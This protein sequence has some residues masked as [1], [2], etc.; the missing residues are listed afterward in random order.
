MD[1]AVNDVFFSDIQEEGTV[2]DYVDGAFIFVIKDEMWT[3][4][5]TKGI[6]K[7]PLQIDFVYK[8]DIPMFLVTIEDVLDT[9]DFIF[10]V[11]D[12]IYDDHLY[13]GSK[14]C[15]HGKVYL[16]DKNNIVCGK[17]SFTM[18]TSLSSCI[19]DSLKKQKEALYNEE[20]FSCNLEG[21]QS[22][23][24]PYELQE[25]ALASECIK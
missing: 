22:T 20:E 17:R 16:L 5:E 25:F 6:N 8:Y 14:H 12:G 1:V 23:W 15:Y 7:K 3:E 21:L 10:N 24:E 13:D 18:S 2:M 19:A 11:H 9:S 4:Y